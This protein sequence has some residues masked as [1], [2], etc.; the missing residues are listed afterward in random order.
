MR[1]HGVI[2]EKPKGRPDPIPA[3]ER[4]R[5]RQ[6]QLYHT[7]QKLDPNYKRMRQDQKLRLAYGIGIDE[8]E[9]LFSKQGGT[10]AICKRPPYKKRLSVDHCHK[11]GKIRGL[12]CFRCNY[13]LA[14]FSDNPER[15]R[16]AAEHVQP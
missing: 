14:W 16:A 7:K 6:R 3:L 15:L 12:L 8:Y 13:G 2:R 4:K 1:G 10:C 11:T 9:A 5:E